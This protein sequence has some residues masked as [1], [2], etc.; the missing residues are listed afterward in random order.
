MRH[1]RFLPKNHGWHKKKDWFGN[2]E[3]EGP[4][5]PLC[6]SDVVNKVRDL[7]GIPLS[8]APHVKVKLTMKKGMI[9]GKRKAVF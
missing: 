7:E 3:L 2:V 1:R 5:I 8:K 6:G 9:I 4:P